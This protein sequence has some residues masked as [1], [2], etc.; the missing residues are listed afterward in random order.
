VRATAPSVR[1]TPA[2]RLPRVQATSASA[3]EII[4]PPRG[5]SGLASRRHPQPPGGFG[6]PIDI[7][8]VPVSPELGAPPVL[9]PPLELI[10]PPVP[11]LVAPP[12]PELVVLPALE[13]VV[14][15]ALELV[16]LLALELVVPL[17]LEL[18]V[19]LA[20]ELVVL[21]DEPPSGVGTQAPAWHVPPGQGVPSD[22]GVG[23][24]HMLVAGAHVPAA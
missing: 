18:V 7:P 1:R 6:P 23:L 2:L 4:A 11:E 14:L 10:A 3:I 20:L 16:V 15:A 21:L 13:L 5:A 12:E 22:F 24:E 19:L 9:I 8:P 17:A